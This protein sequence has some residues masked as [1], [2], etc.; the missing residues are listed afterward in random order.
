MESTEP[1]KR[2]SQLLIESVL[3]RLDSKEINKN[4][5]LLAEQINQY[6]D[7]RD[8]PNID[9]VAFAFFYYVTHYTSRI[10][11]VEAVRVLTAFMLL[12][13]AIED[14]ESSV[15]YGALYI[16]IKRKWKTLLPVF[17]YTLPEDLELRPLFTLYKS[18]PLGKDITSIISDNYFTIKQYLL[19]IILGN[20]DQLSRNEL[21]GDSIKALISKEHKE[22]LESEVLRGS[23]LIIKSFKRL[24]YYDKYHLFA[25]SKSSSDI[26][27]ASYGFICEDFIFDSNSFILCDF[28]RN[29]TLK[30]F[31]DNVNLF[32]LFEGQDIIIRQSRVDEN[33]LI[34]ETKQSISSITYVSFSNTIEINLWSDNYGLEDNVPICID[35]EKDSNT[36]TGV[37]LSFLSGTGFDKTIRQLSFS[38][39]G[40][41]TENL[42]QLSIHMSNKGNIITRRTD[43]YSFL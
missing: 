38:G 26:Y 24:C 17:Y 3:R 19:H 5:V 25:P 12:M 20:I 6:E 27:K 2:T 9:D 39:E 23:E 8:I 37:E 22:I 36:I 34:K 14:N 30:R 13:Y 40:Y 7:Y 10:Q 35:I 16:L 29:G 43:D 42:Q 28:G 11:E 4:W 1:I 15:Y 21:I 33:L 31:R 18:G 41:Y 32:V